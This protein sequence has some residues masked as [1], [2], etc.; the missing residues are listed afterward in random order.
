MKQWKRS[1][2]KVLISILADIPTQLDT[3]QDDLLWHY[4]CSQ[5][6]V[7]LETSTGP[8]HPAQFCD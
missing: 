7:G 8:F 3:A 1:P 6:E 4:S 5:Q 2:G